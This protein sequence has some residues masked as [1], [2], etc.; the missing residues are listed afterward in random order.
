M[1]TQWI[2]SA[3]CLPLLLV[4]SSCQRLKECGPE[5]GD[6]PSSYSCI[7]YV[8]GTP[9]R[10]ELTEPGMLEISNTPKQCDLRTVLYGV[11]SAGRFGSAVASN[12]S[13]VLIGESGKNAIHLY[14]LDGSGTFNENAQFGSTA[15]A[16]S[17]QAGSDFGRS[18]ALGSNEAYAVGV[19]GGQGYRKNGATWVSNGSSYKGF[20]GNARTVVSDG[21]YIALGVLGIGTTD[22]YVYRKTEAMPC[23]HVRPASG[24]SLPGFGDALGFTNGVLVIGG[25]D[26]QSVHSASFSCTSGTEEMSQAILS[27]ASAGGFGKSVAVSGS[28]LVVGAPDQSGSQPDF[29]TFKQNGTTWPAEDNG[30]SRAR[31]ATDGIGSALAI[32][33]DLVVV[34]A[35]GVSSAK[36]EATIY[37][38]LNRQWVTV[39]RADPGEI[40]KVSGGVIGQLGK[41][42]AVSGS[43]VVIGAPFSRQGAVDTGAAVIYRCE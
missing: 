41:S 40:E 16:N 24:P 25:P 31:V 1:S 20:T 37:Q 6:C 5:Y 14:D 15:A 10:C 27:M 13:S 21:T 35:P 26:E 19:A 38:R 9:G 8:S 11:E 2:V 22:V 29:F 7:G 23:K 32:D 43:L 18:V 28:T 42:V 34:G 17:A 4:G 30:P 39:L 3:A 36:G 12:G 33:G